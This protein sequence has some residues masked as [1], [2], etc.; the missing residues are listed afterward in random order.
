MCSSKI[1]S[2]VRFLSLSRAV[3]FQPPVNLPLSIKASLQPE[4][5]HDAFPFHRSIGV[6]ESV[7]HGKHYI[8]PINLSYKNLDIG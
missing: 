2:A 4:L 3:V 8:S 6:S 1:A 5:L 7:S